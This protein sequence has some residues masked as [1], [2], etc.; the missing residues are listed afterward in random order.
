MLLTLGHQ[1]DYIKL[2]VYDETNQNIVTTK[3]G[4]YEN[5]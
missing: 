5:K 2:I 3:N 1:N 4:Q